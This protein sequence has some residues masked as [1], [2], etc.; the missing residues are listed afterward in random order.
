MS[1]I[2]KPAV[3]GLFYPDDPSKLKEMI[4]NLLSVAPANGF[5]GDIF[6]IVVPHAGYVYSGFTAAHA[7]NLVKGK[8]FKTIIIISPSHREYFPGISIY[9]GDAF[10]TPFGMVE[11]D[12]ELSARLLEG[13]KDFLLGEI[14]HREEHAIEVEIPFLQQVIEDF[15]I[16]PVVMGDQKPRYIN[17][18]ARKLAAIYEEEI[19]VVASSDLSHYH[20]RKEAEELDGIVARRI[21]D[22]DYEKLMVDLEL[23]HCEACG[24]GPVVALMKAAAERKYDKSLLLNRTDSGDVT[25]D[26]NEVVGYLS[27][28]IYK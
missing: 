22:F 28:V 16:V 2:R 1:R 4:D 17:E 8:N 21:S 19:L 6:G 26:L 10:E 20:S 3:A 12:K 14:G 23:K 13:S 27:A 7:F 18:L 24:G 15:K 5:K 25:G 11:I 9:D